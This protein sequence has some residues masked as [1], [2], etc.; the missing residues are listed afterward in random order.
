MWEGLGK[1]A[2]VVQLIGLDARQLV[3]GTVRTRQAASQNKDDCEL[4][5]RR[6]EI[7][8]MRFPPLGLGQE[9][10]DLKR[11]RAALSKAEDLINSYEGRGRVSKIFTARV[12][13]IFT[14]NRVADEFRDVQKKIDSCLLIIQEKKDADC[15]SVSTSASRQSP[16]QTEDGKEEAREEEVRVSNPV[17]APEDQHGKQ[18]E[19]GPGPRRG[20]TAQHAC[21]RPTVGV[22]DQDAA[23]YK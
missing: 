11:L 12:P 19:D 9:D 10:P 15:G 8:R 14:A 17:S 16:V 1:A 20:T 7:L 13:K 23:V 18:A 21:P 3:T 4:L 2:N 6:V 22:A 5:K